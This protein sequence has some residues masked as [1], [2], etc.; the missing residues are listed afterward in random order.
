MVKI[1]SA[2]FGDKFGRTD[3]TNSV[4]KQAKDGQV[5][6][7]VNS[8]LIPMIDRATGANSTALTDQEKR[9]ITD[10]VATMCGPTDQAC[11]EIKTQELADAKIRQKESSKSMSTA[12]IIKGRYGDFEYIDDN[13]QLRRARVPEGQT[14]QINKLGQQDSRMPPQDISVSA[15]KQ[16]FGE[17][18]AT[19]RKS[20][21]L[22]VY[23]ASIVITWMTFVRYGSKLVAGVMTAIA[24]FIPLSG[25]GLAFFGV[26]I[27]E[28]LRLENE[29]RLR[30][31]TM[32]LT[33][34]PLGRK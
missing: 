6:V 32:T 28:Y 29:T 5:E 7:Q 24:F 2:T 18:W 8:S 3:V 4:V 19:F 10:A 30:L 9:D 22:F 21:L 20:I 25:Y 34:N 13:G 17:F 1:V 11:I 15:V 23:V 31:P 12:E 16:A 26:L 14:F 27:Y 33:E